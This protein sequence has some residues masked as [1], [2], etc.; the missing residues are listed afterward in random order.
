LKAL[1]YGVPNDRRLLER[2]TWGFGDGGV[3]C[4]SARDGGRFLF[5]DGGMCQF[6]G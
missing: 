1:A 2:R 6:A 4:F 5:A 3:F